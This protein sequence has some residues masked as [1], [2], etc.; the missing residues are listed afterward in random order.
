LPDPQQQ[1]SAS[2]AVGDAAR[3]RVP[4][5]H[6]LGFWNNTF[7]LWGWVLVLSSLLVDEVELVG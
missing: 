7:I 3:S 5:S 6:R 4:L 2:A 1:T